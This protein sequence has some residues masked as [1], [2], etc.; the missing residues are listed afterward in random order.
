LSQVLWEAKPEYV[1][2]PKAGE[3][4]RVLPALN[5]LG[6]NAHTLTFHHHLTLVLKVRSD[7]SLEREPFL[8]ILYNDGFRV[9]LHKLALLRFFLRVVGDGTTYLLSSWKEPSAALEQHEKPADKH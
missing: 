7:E 9:F 1:L 8:S 4:R 5:V 2:F 3:V 6:G